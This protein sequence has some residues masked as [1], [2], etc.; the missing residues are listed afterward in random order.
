M[1]GHTF[2]PTQV[3]SLS[4]TAPLANTLT[5]VFSIGIQGLS[6]DIGFVPAVFLGA[7]LAA[8]LF[9]ELRWQRFTSLQSSLRYIVGA[10]LMGTGSVMALGCEVGN[11]SN[12]T[13][14]IT[15]SW[16]ALGIMWL[17]L[18]LTQRVLDQRTYDFGANPSRHSVPAKDQ[19]TIIVAASAANAHL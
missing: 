19:E 4:F 7:L 14:M 18:I 12:A 17:A 2:E 3:E 5:Y 16:A 1:S 9:G 13:V 8:L 11:L 6:F 15:T 10:A